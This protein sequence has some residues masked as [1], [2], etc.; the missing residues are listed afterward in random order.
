L[1][2][3][4]ISLRRLEANRRNAR[5]STGPRTARGRAIA[6]KNATRHGL[7]AARVALT[8][9]ERARYGRRLR[10]W[11]AALGPETGAEREAV[12]RAVRA[13]ILVE[14]V[15][16][17]DALAWADPKD[18]D[19]DRLD[20]SARLVGRFSRAL[21]A[22]LRDVRALRRERLAEA[23]KCRNEAKKAA[24]QVVEAQ[25]LGT[26]PPSNPA[27]AGGAGGSAVDR[28]ARR[29]NG[30]NEPKRVPPQT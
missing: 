28:G 12:A 7:D 29:A 21:Q 8:G 2:T 6:S 9:A 16:A 10:K 15:D 11:S 30:R 18:P 20:A 3:T 5:K 19:L 23:R 17:L 27:H 26:R 25:S 14:R 13:S 22:A 1:T 4:T 24:T